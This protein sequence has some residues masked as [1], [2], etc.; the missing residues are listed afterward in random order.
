MLFKHGACLVVT[1]SFCGAAYLI[2]CD[3]GWI[4]LTLN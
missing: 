4:C 3:A 1:L 2:S